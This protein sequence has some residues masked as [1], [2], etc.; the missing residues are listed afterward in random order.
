MSGAHVSL[1]AGM[2]ALL[3]RGRAERRAPAVVL[4][5]LVG[6]YGTI[7]GL[8]PPVVRA[9]VGFALLLLAQRHGRRLPITAALAAPGLATALLWPQDA[10]S[11]SFALSYAAVAGLALAPSLRRPAGLGQRLWIAMA[12]SGWAT[13]TTA[14]LTLAWFGQLAPWTILATPLLGPLVA[15]LLAGGLVLASCGAVGTELPWLAQL[16]QTTARGWARAR[17]APR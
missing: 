1:L 15:L 10:R 14:P 5:V 2:L 9:L 16:L 8:D 11:A 6:L 3:L 4:L 7:T 17:S 13:L 12:A